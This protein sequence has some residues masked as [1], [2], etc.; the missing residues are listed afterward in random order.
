MTIIAASLVNVMRTRREMERALHQGDWDAVK[1]WDSKVGQSLD[2]AFDDPS[3][4]NRALVDELEKV[5]GLYAQVVAQLPEHT[6]QQ[7]LRREPSA[8]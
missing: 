5:L 2:A 8:G 1:Q 4:D 7:W 6:A 3:R